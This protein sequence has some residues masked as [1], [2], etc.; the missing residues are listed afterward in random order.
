M[1]LGK[2]TN[3]ALVVICLLALL[4]LSIVACGGEEPKY[5]EQQVITFVS[6][7][8]AGCAESGAKENWVAEFEGSHQWKVTK[9]CIVGGEVVSREVWYFDEQLGKAKGGHIYN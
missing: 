9:Q 7:Q 6:L 4:S 8:A 3:R 2:I 1:I 5:T